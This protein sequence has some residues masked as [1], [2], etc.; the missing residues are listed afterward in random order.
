MLCGDFNVN[1]FK[2][3]N[4][5]KHIETQFGL[6]CLNSTIPTTRNN[7]SC[8]DLTFA[9]KNI[10]RIISLCQYV[11]YFSLHRPILH[12]IYFDNDN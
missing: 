1:I 3:P 12:K 4:F 6:Y 9:S 2:S 7:N 10:A 11:S 5:L 8:I